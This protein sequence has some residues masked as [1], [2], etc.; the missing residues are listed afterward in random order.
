MR[1]SYVMS[2]LLG[3]AVVPGTVSAQFYQQDF[4]ATFPPPVE[5]P[6]RVTVIMINESG[7][8]IIPYDNFPVPGLTDYVGRHQVAARTGGANANQEISAITSVYTLNASDTTE[9]YVIDPLPATGGNGVYP[10]DIVLDDNFITLSEDGIGD[11]QSAVAWDEQYAGQ[12]DTARHDFVFRI[13]GIGNQANDQ[14]D[15]LGWAYLN[16]ANYGTTGVSG[17]GISEEPNFAGSLGVGFDIWDNGGEGGNSVSLHFDGRVLDS[18]PIDPGTTNPDTGLDWEFNSFET[19]ELI[20]TT[21]LMTPGEDAGT[22]VPV[23]KGGS[24]YSTFNQGGRV[25]EIIQV[26]GADSMDG[27]LRIAEEAAGVVNTIAFD[28]DGSGA[29]N[30]YNISFEFRGFSEDTTRAD[31]MSFLLVPTDLYDETGA[32]L[33]NFGPHEEPNLAGAGNWI[34]YVQQ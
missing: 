1:L 17:P 32:D 21:V 11:I 6:G 2:I 23:L 27:H 4:S 15:G 7:D 30:E 5:N 34:R 31:G 8:T 25:S 29:H 9:Q 28:Y 13:S 33:I 26:G 12:Y 16:S 18:R 22:Q 24:P 19:D 20:Q 3:I 10:P 14:A